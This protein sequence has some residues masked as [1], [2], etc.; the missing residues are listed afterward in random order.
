MKLDAKNFNNLFGVS[1]PSPKGISATTVTCNFSQSCITASS[2]I[3][4][5]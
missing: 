1:A 2:M 4:V 3:D 5:K